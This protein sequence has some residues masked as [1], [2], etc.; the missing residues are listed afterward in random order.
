[1]SDALAGL[2]QQV[3]LDHSKQRT[4]F[5][6]LEHADAQRFER[7]PTCGDEI[8]LQ[9]DMEPGTDRI[10]SLAWHGSGCSISQASASVLAGLAPGLTTVE[11][12]TTIDEFRTMMRSRGVGEPDE[13]L[14]GDA[15]VFQGVSKYVMRVKCA[16]L[17]WVALEGCLADVA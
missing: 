12:H 8:T 16:M 11:L 3:I 13:D 7:N 10:A 15:V 14:L 9:I 17:S 1:M 2:Y 6:E 4:G 5:G